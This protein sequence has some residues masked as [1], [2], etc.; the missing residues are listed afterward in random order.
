VDQKRDCIACPETCQCS[1]DLSL[2]SLDDRT[3]KRRFINWVA[4]RS[5]GRSVLRSL[6]VK[7]VGGTASSRPAGRRSTPDAVRRWS[8]NWS[9]ASRT[10]DGGRVDLVMTES[11]WRLMSCNVARWS[12]KL[13]EW[14]RWDV[15]ANHTAL[16]PPV[17][18][19]ASCHH[20][21]RSC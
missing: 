18:A 13:I 1:M 6:G 10:I 15:T 5:V 11:H 4:G 20:A 19:V 8:A 2:S 16:Q 7:R 12:T 21:K 14:T 9:L 3:R 17:Q